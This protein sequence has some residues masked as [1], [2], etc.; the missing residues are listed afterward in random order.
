[1][2]AMHADGDGERNGEVAVGVAHVGLD[3]GD[4]AVADHADDAEQQAEP[5]ASGGEDEGGEEHADYN[6][7]SRRFGGSLSSSCHSL[8]YIT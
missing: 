8:G 1:M 2:N 3:S 6:R 5:H 7:R 4:E